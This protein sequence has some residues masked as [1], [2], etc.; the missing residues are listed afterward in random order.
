MA[1][2]ESEPRNRQYVRLHHLA[3][4]HDDKIRTEPFDERPSLECVEGID[5]EYIDGRGE[6]FL[7]GLAQAE[8]APKSFVGALQE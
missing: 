8:A 4:H 5:L 1:A 3:R 6:H 7:R 2:D